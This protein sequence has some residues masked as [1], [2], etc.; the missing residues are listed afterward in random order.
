MTRAATGIKLAGHCVNSSPIC[1]WAA[2]MKCGFMN[3][4]LAFIVI[5]AAYQLTVVSSSTI[6]GNAAEFFVTPEDERA[7]SA[8]ASLPPGLT[9]SFQ[10]LTQEDGKLRSNGFARDGIH[11]AGGRTDMAQKLA[12]QATLHLLFNARAHKLSYP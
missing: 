1:T 10:S 3:T 7:S 11:E 2:E 6:G 9:G 8:H 5:D 12:M 4:R